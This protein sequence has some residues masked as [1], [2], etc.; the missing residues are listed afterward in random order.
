MSCF[1]SC[2]NATCFVCLS[3]GY[4]T[5]LL[6]FCSSCLFSVGTTVAELRRRAL[7]CV[8]GITC[9]WTLTLNYSWLFGWRHWIVVRTSCPIPI[10]HF[11]WIYAAFGSRA[12]TLTVMRFNQAAGW[13]QCWHIS[14]KTIAFTHRDCGM[15]VKFIS[16]VLWWLKRILENSPRHVAPKH[17]ARTHIALHHCHIFLGEL[18]LWILN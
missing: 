11:M 9:M 10:I 7:T 12:W 4:A 8:L 2:P 16:I 1:Q 15:A 17:D 3:P 5:S 18:N 14:S 13:W 6:D